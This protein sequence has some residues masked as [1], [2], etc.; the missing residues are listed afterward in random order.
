MVSP[1][2]ESVLNTVKKLLGIPEDYDAFDIDILLHINTVLAIMQQI[3]AVKPDATVESDKTIWSDI[4]KDS[5]QY[6]YARSY[7]VLKVRLLF[8]PPQSSAVRE[9][10]DKSIS[11]M[12]WRLTVTDSALETT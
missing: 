2:N 9:A 4:I 11:E 1:Y 12:E 7:I 6:N 8:D 5:A 3:G 10:I